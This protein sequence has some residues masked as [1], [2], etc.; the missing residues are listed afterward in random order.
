MLICQT[1]SKF[2]RHGFLRE[3]LLILTC[4]CFYSLLYKT[5]VI[6]DNHTKNKV[7]ASSFFLNP[8][9]QS[10]GTLIQQLHT[11]LFLASIYKLDA[12]TQFKLF[13][14]I[15]HKTSKN[16]LMDI[17]LSN[18]FFWFVCVCLEAKAAFNLSHHIILFIRSALY[19][20]RYKFLFLRHCF[21]SICQQSKFIR[22]IRHL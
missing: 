10:D 1:I 3:I 22:N 6:F 21:H 16:K 17:Y 7:P 19:R 8:I 4:F 18:I 20:L 9:N 13:F 11:V 14:L 2:E 12:L 5:Q 15:Q